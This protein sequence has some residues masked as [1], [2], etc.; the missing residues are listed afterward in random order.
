[1]RHQEEDDFDP[2]VLKDGESYRVPLRLCDSLQRDIAQHFAQQAQPLCVTD[3]FGVTVGLHRPG[4]R[5]LT[6]GKVGD[7]LVRDSA[8]ADRAAAYRDYER[9]ITR[10]WRNEGED[11]DD[12]DASNSSAR[13]NAATA[14]A[15]YAAELAEAWRGK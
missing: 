11:G 3:Q 6:G 12:C 2:R 14:Y 10:A 1:M 13:A 7:Q 9:T 15:A 8:L 5:I 4:P